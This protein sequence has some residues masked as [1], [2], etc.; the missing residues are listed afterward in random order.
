MKRMLIYV[1][2]CIRLLKS[3]FEIE[4]TEVSL[5]GLSIKRIGKSDLQS[6]QKNKDNLNERET[7]TGSRPT[8]MLRRKE[9]KQRKTRSAMAASRKAQYSWRE[10]KRQGRVHC[11]KST[12]WSETWV[13]SH[14]LMQ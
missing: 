1:N 3:T 8:T 10:Q 5:W 14:G 7:D 6:L 4:S 2:M 11:V 12:F 9:G 13:M